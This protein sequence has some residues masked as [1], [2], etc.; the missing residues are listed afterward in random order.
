VNLS[1]NLHACKESLTFIITQENVKI[2]QVIYAA[3]NQCRLNLTYNTVIYCF[4]ICVSNNLHSVSRVTAFNRKRYSTRKCLRDFGKPILTN[5]FTVVFLNNCC[6][7]NPVS[8][9]KT[10]R[11]FS[12][13]YLRYGDI[14]AE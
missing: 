3:K 9:C 7:G 8:E 10:M 12:P 11:L 1:V 5:L 4:F 13:L 6:Y 2:F 14:P